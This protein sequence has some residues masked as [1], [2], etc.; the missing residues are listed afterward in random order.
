VILKAGY[1]EE[2]LFVVYLRKD[3]MN[4]QSDGSWADII[5][6]KRGIKKCMMIGVQIEKKERKQKTERQDDEEE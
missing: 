6:N 5:R 3:G 4:K 1:I 2:K